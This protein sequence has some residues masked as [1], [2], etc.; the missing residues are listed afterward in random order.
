MRPNAKSNIVICPFVADLQ[1]SVRWLQAGGRA[2]GIMAVNHNS[3]I[4]YN[5][6]R[7]IVTNFRT[8][9]EYLQS[10]MELFSSV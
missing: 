1:P 3:V 10:L 7:S 6:K 4:P 5:T 2:A 9:I 8:L